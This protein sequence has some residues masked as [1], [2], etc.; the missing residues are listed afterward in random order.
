MIREAYSRYVTHCLR[1]YARYRKPEF[2]SDIDR[3]NWEACD[4]ALKLFSDSDRETLLYIYRERDTI[5]DNIY[6]LA[7]SW[8][9]S[10][11][12]IWELVVKLERKVAELRGLAPCQ[13]TAISPRN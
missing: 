13:T 11:D 4:N 2:R 12:N 7:M 6:R 10:Q 8:G 1:F 5:P 9:I 3:H